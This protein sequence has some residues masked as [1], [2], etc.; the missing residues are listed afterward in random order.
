MRHF[1]FMIILRDVI[2]EIESLGEIPKGKPHH[3][4]QLWDFRLDRTIDRVCEAKESL[5]PLSYL[6]S[7]IAILFTAASWCLHN[8]TDEKE[9]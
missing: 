6:V 1:R 9:E 3:E 2:K 4:A 8:E 5:A 7:A